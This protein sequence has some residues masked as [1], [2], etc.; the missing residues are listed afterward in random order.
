MRTCN[1]YGEKAP[2]LKKWKNIFQKKTAASRR[3]FPALFVEMAAADFEIAAEEEK[4]IHNLLS[5]IFSLGKS[6]IDELIAGAA[7]QRRKRNDIWYFTNLIKGRFSREQKKDIL[8]K[9][10]TLIYA[11][12]RVDRYEDMLMRKV[13]T[14]LG[15]EHHDM[16]EAKHN[17]K[18]K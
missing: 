3:R 14:L 11:D 7:I 10:W 5:E 2:C 15:M 6:E 8:E 1:D 9:L 4:H 16:I 17:A 13:T 12:G 18:K